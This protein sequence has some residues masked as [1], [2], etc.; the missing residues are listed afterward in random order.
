MDTLLRRQNAGEQQFD[1]WLSDRPACTWGAQG[2]G[3]RASSAQ[4]MTSEPDVPLE[5]PGAAELHLEPASPAE[6]IARDALLFTFWGG[7]W[8]VEQFHAREVVLNS[9]PWARSSKQTWLLKDRAAGDNVVASSDT[10]RLSGLLNGVALDV[11]LG[12]S[13]FV[14]AEVRGLGMS[15]DL[16]SRVQQAVQS[17]SRA[18]KAVFAVFSDVGAKPYARVGLGVCDPV[19]MDAVIRLVEG[20]SRPCMTEVQRG[21]A[22]VNGSLAPAS[23]RDPLR[24]LS[25]PELLDEWRRLPQSDLL[26][27]PPGHLIAT[28]SAEQ[29]QWHLAFAAVQRDMLAPHVKPLPHAG[30]IVF[31]SSGVVPA[32]PAAGIAWALDTCA[33][34]PE[35]LVLALVASC[36][37]QVE[38]LLRCAVETAAV[39]GVAVVRVWD[40]ELTFL[41]GAGAGGAAGG[42]DATATHAPAAASNHGDAAAATFQSVRLADICARLSTLVLD[43]LRVVMELE[44]RDGALPMAG[45]MHATA[46]SGDS[47]AKTPEPELPPLAVLRD[48]DGSAAASDGAIEPCHKPARCGSVPPASAVLTTPIS[49]WVWLQRGTWN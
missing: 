2:H 3:L 16:L 30:A 4:S 47:A 32:E 43:G 1:C 22:V 10:F 6:N 15:K 8:S 26:R 28:V 20:G 49:K 12:S 42:G 46:A 44:P 17:S 14:N 41:T 27:A 29:L 11:F 31:D 23:L 40:T 34:T 33:A 35:L 19:P 45:L 9:L 13:V 37:E 24:T 38:S 25:E 5:R 36:E 39:A 18:A 48:G 21:A 7:K